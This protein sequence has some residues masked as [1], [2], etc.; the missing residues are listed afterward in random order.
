MIIQCYDVNFSNNYNYY[1]TFN[2]LKISLLNVL[3]AII[4]C[5]K[6][7]KLI[8]F[9][10]QIFQLENKIVFT[11]NFIQKNLSVLHHLINCSL[12]NL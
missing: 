6:L 5:F 11:E 7:L 1:K 9:I 10:C 12:D 2:F 8:S 3:F 4:F